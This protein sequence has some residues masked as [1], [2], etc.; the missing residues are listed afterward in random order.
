MKSTISCHNNLLVSGGS[1]RFS[2][3]QALHTHI[4]SHCLHS[5]PGLS[6]LCLYIPN[7]PL[8]FSCYTPRHWT[9][10]ECPFSSVQL[11]ATLHCSPPGSSVH[12]VSQARILEWVSIPSPRDLP[13]PGI[14]PESLASPALAHRFSTSSTSWDPVT[15]LWVTLNLESS[16]LQIPNLMTFAKTFFFK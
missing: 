3:F 5:P 13:K 7:F 10:H 8:P 2:A 14:K 6:P 9:L 1:W 11:M 4:S 15:G 16:Y 12:R